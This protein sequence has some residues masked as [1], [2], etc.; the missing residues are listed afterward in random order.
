MKIKLDENLP[1]EL[2]ELLSSYSH[3]VDTV[4][5]E[6]LTG[7]DDP[8]I[9]HAAVAAERMLYYSHPIRTSPTFEDSN[10]GHMRVWF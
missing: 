4:P 2:T 1:L 10:P 6:K 9:F 3:D 5:G 8:T 7:R